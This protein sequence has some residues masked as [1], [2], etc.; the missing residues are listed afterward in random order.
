MVDD[1]VS[2]SPLNP[3]ESDEVDRQEILCLSPGR[4]RL[5]GMRRFL[6]RRVVCRRTRTKRV[7]SNTGFVL[8]C[9]RSVRTFPKLPVPIVS[10]PCRDV[11][12]G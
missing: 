1:V 7:D 9:Y 6:Q 2:F 8:L 4:V 12:T 10:L 5:R 11:G 3:K